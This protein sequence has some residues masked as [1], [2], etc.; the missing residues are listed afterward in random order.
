MEMYLILLNLMPYLTL[1]QA[2]RRDGLKGSSQLIGAVHWP[3]L[4]RAKG[5][6]DTTTHLAPAWLGGRGTGLRV[7]CRKEMDRA[8]QAV[9]QRLG[10]RADTAR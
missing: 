4:L 9:P 7:F 3:P 8:Y 1:A 5:P 10:H 6:P 2:E